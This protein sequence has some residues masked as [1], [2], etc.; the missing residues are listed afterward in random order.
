MM[1][2]HQIENRQSKSKILF[3]PLGRAEVEVHSSD[4]YYS[5]IPGEILLAQKAGADESV[6]LGD[7]NLVV[8]N[9]KTPESQLLNATNALSAAGQARRQVGANSGGNR[10][11]KK[12]K[13]A[14]GI[15]R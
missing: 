6:N 15:D 9:N 12:S 3:L 10:S 5:K 2:I 8:A 11:R 4:V 13:A 7:H 14:S 1:R